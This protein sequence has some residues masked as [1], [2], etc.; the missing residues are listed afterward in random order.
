[1][2]ECAILIFF[3][4][5]YPTIIILN[6]DVYLF[7]NHEQK[8]CAKDVTVH[9]PLNRETRDWM[10]DDDAEADSTREQVS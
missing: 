2:R 3:S 9:Q 7:T 6:L 4:L 1:M 10:S 8:I 5:S